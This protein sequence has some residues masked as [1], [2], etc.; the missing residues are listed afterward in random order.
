MSMTLS[1]AL[2][3]SGGLATGL[4]AAIT[5]FV[6]FGTNNHREPVTSFDYL[7]I[8]GALIILPLLT[9]TGSYIHAVKREGLGLTMLAVSG[10][11][12]FLIFL[13]QTLVVL[14]SWYYPVWLA[15]VNLAPSMLAMM[16]M[17]VA[18]YNKKPAK[19]T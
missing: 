3:L 5:C 7:Y 10:L 17:C 8:L 2:E 18:F 11:L 16:T 1:G 12:S 4:S 14:G 9:L 15:L 13:L 6:F 19:F